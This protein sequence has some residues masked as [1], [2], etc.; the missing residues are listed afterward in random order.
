LISPASQIRRRP[1]PGWQ[2]TPFREFVLKVAGRCDLDCDYCYM[3]HLADQRWTA[4]PR[5]IEEHV[6]RR[7]AA[8][9]GAHVRR[10]GLDQVTVIL[11]GGEPLLA[12][13]ERLARIAA[14]VRA[15]LPEGTTVRVSVQTNG[16]RLT[17]PALAT[18]R[19]AGIRVAVSLDG[20][21]ASHDRHRRHANG[22]GSHAAVDAGLRRLTRPEY[23]PLFAGLLCVVDLANDPE[24]VYHA[25]AGHRPPVIDFLLPFGNWSAP[26]PGRAPDGSAPYG[27]WLATAFDTWYSSPAGRPEIRL[28][29]ELITLLCGGQSRSEQIGLSPSAMIVFNADGSIEQVDSL[30]SAFE[31]AVDTGFSVVTHDLEDALAHPAVMLRQMGVAALSAECRDCRLVTVCGGG[32]YVHRYRSGTGFDNPSVYCSDLAYLIGHVRNRVR[33]D[34]AALR[35]SSR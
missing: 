23:R 27:A 30:R 1:P 21:A 8:V 11:H 35:E 18:L 6:V 13:A 15:A 17:E 9:I 16:V 10:H 25:L 14:T 32:H 19:D 33:R 29:R 31:G 22:A 7:A 4:Q 12:G 34:V 26:P 28:F 3:Y 20:D 2:P 5:I 24:T